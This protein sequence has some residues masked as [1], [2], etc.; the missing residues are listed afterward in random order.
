MIS[1][2]VLEQL[3]SPEKRVY[4]LMEIHTLLRPH[5]YGLTLSDFARLRVF[6]PMEPGFSYC[7]I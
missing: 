6:R 1:V 5:F 4:A 2:V 7:F 3:R